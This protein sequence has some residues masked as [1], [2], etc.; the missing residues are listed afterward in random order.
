[1]FTLRPGVRYADGS[2]VRTGDFRASLERALSRT[3]TS[4]LSAIAGAATCSRRCDL[5]AGIEDDPRSR[6]ITVH[7]AHPDSDFLHELTTP[8][9]Y[10]VPAGAGHG[11]PPGTGPYRVAGWNR[12]AGGTFLRNPYFRGPRRPAGFADRIDVGIVAEDDVERGIA[13]VERG[14]ADVLVLADPFGSHV[15]RARLRAL[16]ARAPSRLHSAPAAST[17]WMFLNVRRRPFDDLAVRQAVSIALDRSQIVASMGGT[18]LAAPTC[19]IVP[20]GFP[21]YAPY[22]PYTDDPWGAGDPRRAQA[23]VA[24]SGRAGERVVVEVP[25]FRRAVGRRFERL[26][27]DLGFRASL[28]VRSLMD[29]FR[30][31]YDANV[32]IGFM[33]WNSDFVSASTFIEPAFS[34]ASQAERDLNNVSHFCDPALARTVAAAREGLGDDANRTWARADRAVIDH[35]AA[36]PLTNHRSLV[37]VSDRVGNVQTH[38]TWMTLLDQLWVR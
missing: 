24:A 10:V 20:P 19:Q 25:D 7:L 2:P 17:E 34:C 16:V 33:G 3:Q 21:G 6:T 30:T 27:D 36:V 28:R 22:C 14:G 18:P 26:L 31:V 38:P 15:D 8:F 12:R 5:S 4:D 32:Q 23:L 1:V 13:T 9:A 29:Y 11:L 35:A 37:L